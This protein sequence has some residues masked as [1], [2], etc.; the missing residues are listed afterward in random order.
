MLISILLM[1]LASTSAMQGLSHARASAA[2]EFL[3]I[4]AFGDSL[5]QGLTHDS[6]ALHPYAI[7]LRQL[8]SGHVPPVQV[9]EARPIVHSGCRVPQLLL[10]VP[11]LRLLPPTQASFNP[12]PPGGV[13]VAAS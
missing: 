7:H 3:R 8:F 5:T 13:A 6:T 9:R 2:S 10:C 11:L 4:L 12:P 1:G